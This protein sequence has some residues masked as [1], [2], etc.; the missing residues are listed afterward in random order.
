MSTVD[1]ATIALAI[2]PPP[3]PPAVI[4]SRPPQAGIPPTKADRD[5]LRDAVRRGMSRDRAVPPLGMDELRRRATA[6][7]AEAGLSEAYLDYAVVNVNN[8]SWRD[9][10][11]AVPFE[12]RHD[13]RAVE[14]VVA[15]LAAGLGRKEAPVASRAMKVPVVLGQARIVVRA[16]WVVG[17]QLGAFE[18]ASHQLIQARCQV[19]QAAKGALG[20]AGGGVDQQAQTSASRGIDALLERAL[21]VAALKGDLS[22]QGV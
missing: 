20:V 18:R 10:L 3:V 5:A 12:R 2:L 4:R 6:A 13:Q 15:A 14:V 8:E 1:P 17:A 21:W 7:L 11:A 9:A 16:D 22:H 19:H